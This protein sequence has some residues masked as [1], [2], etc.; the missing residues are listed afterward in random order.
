M[1]TGADY[2]KY[3]CPFSHVEKEFGHKLEGPEGFES[4]GVWCACGFRG[5][6]MVLDPKELK[7]ELIDQDNSQWIGFD[8]DGTF[9]LYDEWKGEEVIGEPIPDVVRRL[10]RLYDDGFRVKIFTARASSPKAVAAIKKWLK[11]NNLP[12]LE[13]TD[14]KDYYIVNDC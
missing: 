8:L 13:V 11:S 9:A 10:L 5:P 7:L 6:A 12:D 4:D 1:K 14:R 2:S 3:R